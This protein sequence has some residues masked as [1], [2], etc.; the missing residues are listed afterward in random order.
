MKKK[1]VLTAAVIAALSVVSCNS[2]KTNS[3]GADQVPIS[4]QP[5]IWSA[6]MGTTRQA[7][8]SRYW[9]TTWWKSPAHQAARQPTSRWRMPTASSWPTH[10]V[11]SQKAPWL[12]TMYWPRRSKLFTSKKSPISYQESIFS[13]FRNMRWDFALWQLAKDMEVFGILLILQ[14][15]YILIFH[16]KYN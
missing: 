6:R 1:L 8:S 14:T 2:K 15:R 10:S 13:C 11:L 9:L 7:A 3:Q 12:S 16:V 5:T 4:T